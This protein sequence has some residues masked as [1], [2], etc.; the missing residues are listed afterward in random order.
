MVV[1]E[2]RGRKAWEWRLYERWKSGRVPPLERSTKHA[3]DN[4]YAGRSIWEE[5]PIGLSEILH[6]LARQRSGNRMMPRARFHPG[7]P[8]VAL[9]SVSEDVAVPIMLRRTLVFD[10]TVETGGCQSAIE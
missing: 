3:L 4:G 1:M 5:T 9:D 10:G 6:F 8:G 7:R 2:E